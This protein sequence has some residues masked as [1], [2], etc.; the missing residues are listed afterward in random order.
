MR[1]LF[2]VDIMGATCDGLLAFFCESK[3]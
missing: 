3:K 1:K 2:G